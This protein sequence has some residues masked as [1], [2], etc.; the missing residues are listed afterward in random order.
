[1]TLQLTIQQFAQARRFLL[2]Q[3]R[4]LEAA[5][6]RHR[7]EE[8][9]A[10]DVYAELAAFQN[11]DGGFGHA[12]EPDVRA[13]VSSVLATTTALQTLRLLHAPA[14]QPLVAG[15]LRYLIAAYD[16]SLQSWPLVPPESEAGAHAPWWNQAGL[17]ERFGHFRINPRAEVLGY[18]FEFIDE[19][20]ADALA[21]RQQLAAPVVSD[22][23]AH[24]SALAGN[25]FLCCQRLVESPG[26]DEPVAVELQRWLLRMAEG[27]VATDPADWG[28]YVLQ[29]LQVAPTRAAPLGI[30]LAHLLPQNLDYVIQSQEADGSWPPAWTWM[31][32]YADEWPQAARE[33]RGV[34]TLERLEWLHAYDRILH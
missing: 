10:D 13:P 24:T 3:A 28:G 18:L 14:Q 9:S 27:A 2:E 22:L 16:A 33:W 30:P 31:E 15:A 34:L 8:G 25:E 20:D 17:A 21:L 26:L 12:L 4:P 19:T 32:A 6:F 23:L 11:P 7:F 5:L 1:M 29:P